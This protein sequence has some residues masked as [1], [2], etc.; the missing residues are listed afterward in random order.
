[1]P[2]IG[3]YFEGIIW[4]SASRVYHQGSVTRKEKLPE[5]AS[6]TGKIGQKE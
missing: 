6:E 4:V 3:N 2:T 1:M 5:T